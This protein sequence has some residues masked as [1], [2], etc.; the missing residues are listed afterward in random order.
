M[1]FVCKTSAVYGFVSNMTFAICHSVCVCALKFC[2]I[3]KGNG[4]WIVYGDHR[5]RN[6]HILFRPALYIVHGWLRVPYL[7]VCLSCLSVCLTVVQFNDH[8]VRGDVIHPRQR[9][10]QFN[11]IRNQEKVNTE[12]ICNNLTFNTPAHARDNHLREAG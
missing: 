6:R 3:I 11:V 5:C 10:F 8:E 9:P 2:K 7:Q 12:G 1:I 4:S